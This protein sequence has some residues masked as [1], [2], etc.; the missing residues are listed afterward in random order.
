MPVETIFE[1]EEIVIRFL[2]GDLARPTLVTFGEYTYR[3]EAGG[4]WADAPA[5]RMGWP[6][7]GFIGRR[8]NWYP[9]RSVHAALGAVRAR[10]G[11]VAVGYGYSM[12]AYGVLKYGQ[13]LGL[14]HGLALSPQLSI[15][16]ED[17]P[18]DPRYHVNHDPLL[19]AGMRV[20]DEDL[21]G[22]AWVIFDPQHCG[23]A[24]NMALLASPRL[25]HLPVRGMFHS[26]IRLM[27]GQTRLEEALDQLVRN[28]L[29]GMRRSLR[30]RRRESAFWCAGM[31]AALL[32]RNRLAPGNTLLMRARAQGLGS[33]DE[34]EVLGEALVTECAIPGRPA[35][36]RHPGP[37]QE[38]LLALPN[39]PPEAH[40]DRTLRL[41]AAGQIEA[42]R[43]AAERGLAEVGPHAGLMTHLGHLLL[44]VNELAKARENLETAVR[45]APQ[46]QWAWV[47]LSIARLRTGDVRAAEEAAREA[48]RLRPTQFH[49]QLALGEALLAQGRPVEAADAFRRAG[50]LGGDGAAAGLQRAQQLAARMQATQ[51]ASLFRGRH[52]LSAAQ[53]PEFSNDFQPVRAAA[54]IAGRGSWL[55]SLFKR[56]GKA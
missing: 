22:Q 41:A 55:A 54:A 21:P 23:D 12:G 40:L 37:I 47:G 48:A 38:R 33:A 46:E 20:R 18:H 39:Q 51:Q 13:A 30:A 35:A 44:G 7:I 27:L 16:P 9:A 25:H 11:A 5:A 29:A 52:S 3:P 2:P 31:G 17:L 43:A 42:S 28:D 14:T 56:L 26:S 53:V 36:H 24:Q 45:L 50:E 15:A 8:P 34:A 49:A 1:D 32:G 4:F 6:A 19:H 10:M